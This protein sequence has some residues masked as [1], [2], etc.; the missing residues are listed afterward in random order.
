MSQSSTR[1]GL[2]YLGLNFLSS[3]A[4]VFCNKIIF[5]W[6]SLPF[7][8]LLSTYHFAVTALGL[9]ICVSL[10][11]F[12]FKKLP[13]GPLF[14]VSLVYALSVPFCNLSIRYNSL[15]FYQISKV[16]IIPVSILLEYFFYNGKLEVRMLLYIIPITIGAFLTGK[17]DISTTAMGVFMATSCVLTSALA[18]QWI[19]IQQAEFKINS[20]QMMLYVIPISVV[21]QAMFIPVFDS[22]NNFDIFTFPWTTDLLFVLFISGLLAFTVNLTIFLSLRGVSPVTYQVV[23]Q[24]KSVTILIGSFVL[25]GQILDLRNIFGMVVTM[26]GVF[27]YTYIKMVPSPQSPSTVDKSIETDVKKTNV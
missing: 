22:N 8:A 23:G 4:T 2:I 6:Y 26:A 19:K 20:M 24:A 12:E 13:W 3:V 5:Q 14:K 16:T 15:S 9:V 7:G 25:F 21:I 11:M 17:T 10:G 1:Q 27:Y 18:Q